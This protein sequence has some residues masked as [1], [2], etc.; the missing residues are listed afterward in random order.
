MI[1][2][3][4]HPWLGGL[5]ADPAAHDLWSAEA[6]LAHYAAFETALATALEHTGRV[7]EGQGAHAADAI[8]SFTPDLEALRNGTRKDGLPIPD[9]ISQMR[10]VAGTAA[11]AVHTGATSQ[12][13]LDTALALT[14]RAVSDLLIQRLQA[15]QTHLSSLQDQFGARSMMGRTRMQAAL[16]ITV[17]DRLETWRA[18]LDDHVSRL[19]TLRP[20][21]ERLQLGGP[22]GTAAGFGQDHPDIMKSMARELGLNPAEQVWH[23]DRSSIAEFG[24]CLS[25]ITGT[26]AKMGQDLCLMAQQGIDDVKISGGGGSS[27]MPHKANPVLAELLVT[28]GRFNATQLSGLHDALI[29]EQERSGAA[30]VLEWMILPQM[31]AATSRSLAAAGELC[32]LI[33][34][35]GQD[36]D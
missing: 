28:L 21:V 8:A 17:F 27:A 14:L 31:T 26:L 19:E 24:N 5:F 9:L 32:D 10:D 12:D 13:V 16:P 3:F 15:V 22:V 4:D 34:G 36:T 1:S 33:T 25:L 6:Q 23:T 29:H 18:P 35:L 20:R 11:P 30:W 7:P 2:V